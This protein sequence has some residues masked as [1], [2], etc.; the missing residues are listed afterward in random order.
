M[1]DLWLIDDKGRGMRASYPEDQCGY[2]IPDG[3]GEVRALTESSRTARPITLSA[4]GLHGYT[5]CDLDLPLPTPGLTTM[6]A[7]ALSV[8]ARSF[9]HYNIDGS[10]VSFVE[11]ARAHDIA[12]LRGI[13]FLEPASECSLPASRA[14]ALTI[15]VRGADGVAM[16]KTAVVEMD[17]CQRVLIDGF[18][19]TMSTPLLLSMLA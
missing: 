4:S 8:P 18:V 6:D 16:E 5:G 14:S 9:C 10:E 13:A 1:P 3:L 7:D 17:G 11:S 15:E 2:N 12:S 19:P